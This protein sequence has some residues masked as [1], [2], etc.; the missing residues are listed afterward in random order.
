MKSNRYTQILAAL[1]LMFLAFQ[2]A[3][4]QN[5]RLQLIHNSGD[6]DAFEI[7]IT[8]DGDS[9]TTLS[10]R[11]ATPFMDIAAGDHEFEYTVAN[12]AG[13]GNVTV[14]PDTVTFEANVSYIGIL[15]GITPLNLDR[16]AY[17]EIEGR[18][19]SLTIITVANA[20][21]VADASN[22][23]E[24]VIHHGSTD[25]PAVDVIANSSTTLADDTDYGQTTDYIAVPAAVFQLDVTPGD[26]NAT[27]LGTFEADLTSYAGLSAVICGSGFI[28]SPDNQ[29]A[30]ALALLV[31]L[32]D[33]TTEVLEDQSVGPIGE[34]EFMGEAPWVFDSFFGEVDSLVSGGHGVQVDKNG[35]IW[36]GN[37]F[38]P[39]RVFSPDG[40]EASFSPINEVTIGATTITLDNCRGLE[41]EADGNIIFA[42]S[43]GPGG[44][45]IR[46]NAETGEG[47]NLFAKGGSQLKV[48]VDGSGFIYAGLVVGINPIS[49][50]EPA[51]FAEVQQ[52]TLD[53]PPSFGRGLAVTEDGFTL[54]TPDLAGSGAP[55]RIWESSDQGVTYPQTDSVWTNTAGEQIFNSNLQTFDWGPGLDENGSDSTLW[56]SVDNA[57]NST[58]NSK[59][60]LTVLDF[61]TKKYW[62][63][64]MPDIGEGLGNGPRGVSFSATGDSL[65]IPVWSNN[66]MYRF[67]ADGLV[68]VERAS[69]VIPRRFELKQNYPNPF[70]PT[71]N[72][73]FRVPELGPVTLKV[74]NTLGQE[75]ATILDNHVVTAGLHEVPFDGSSLASGVYYYKLQNNG[76]EATQKMTIMK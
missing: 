9:L 53:G 75:V 18:E 51:F 17:V 37:F 76:F 45:I 1:L 36:I 59:N 27:V 13:G 10:Y 64:S 65:Y 26:D 28:S 16:D 34:W 71:T 67:V 74:Y 25:A 52:I 50:I 32:A 60:N 39:L 3:S 38:S 15:D 33:G 69:V 66:V 61:S 42:Q 21:E 12:P 41:I 7:P 44:N 24:F 58:D 8:V 55:L 62:T 35:N 2:P 19:I 31:V 11:T 57:V 56:V 20:R 70:N 49:V 5:A 4:A 29:G 72:I 47:M 43:G 54:F 14:G 48:G 6:L 30:S 46:I 63:L 22:M 40:V 68:S 23:V 73:A